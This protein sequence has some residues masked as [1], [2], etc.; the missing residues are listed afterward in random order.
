VPIKGSVND[1]GFSA[2]GHTRFVRND[3]ARPKPNA[4]PRSGD[5]R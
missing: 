4:Q 2:E 3:E 1:G 5:I